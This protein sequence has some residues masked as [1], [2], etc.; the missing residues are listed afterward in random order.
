MLKNFET[1]FPEEKWTPTFFESAEVRKALCDL[2]HRNK[3]DVEKKVRRFLDQLSDM[4]VDEWLGGRLKCARDKDAGAPVKDSF[5]KEVGIGEKGRDDVLRSVGFFDRVPIDR[6]ERRF[7]IRTGIFHYCSGW[8]ADP[9]SD[10]SYRISLANFCRRYLKGIKINNL[11]LGEN[12]GILD[13]IIF[14][15]C[16]VEDHNICGDKPDC[17]HCILAE[18]KACLL[19]MLRS[20][21]V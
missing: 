13:G 16:S 18:N 4:S 11:D 7:Q 6:H 8:D 12:P 15:F 10:V 3:G 17:P 14:T 20:A 1:R 2:K 21:R 19:D 9:E 5:L